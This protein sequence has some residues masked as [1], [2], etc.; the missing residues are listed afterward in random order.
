[1]DTER[2]KWLADKSQLQTDLDDALRGR[3]EE[4]EKAAQLNAEVQRTCRS[5]DCRH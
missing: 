1:M 4:R 5:R 2:T 3:D